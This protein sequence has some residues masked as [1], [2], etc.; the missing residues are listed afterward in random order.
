M[1]Q[2]INAQI[3]LSKI[4]KTKIKEVTLKSGRTAKYLD[5]SIVVTDEPDNYGNN[6]SISIGQTKE[7][8]EAKKDRVFIGNGKI[9]WTDKPAPAIGEEKKHDDFPDLPF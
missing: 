4:D 7:E 9:T 5:I 6:A 2:I 1:K 3:D 8:R